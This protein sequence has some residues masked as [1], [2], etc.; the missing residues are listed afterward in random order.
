MPGDN[1]APGLTKRAVRANLD[2]DVDTSNLFIF[3]HL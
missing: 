1:Q 2:D 3:L